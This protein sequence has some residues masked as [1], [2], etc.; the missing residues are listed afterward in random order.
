[1]VKGAD[2]KSVMRRFESGRRLHLLESDRSRDSLRNPPKETFKGDGR[3]L[4]CVARRLECRP[5]PLFFISAQHGAAAYLCARLSWPRDR[6]LNVAPTVSEL[7][8]TIMHG[9]V[10]EQPPLQPTKREPDAGVAVS[11]TSVAAG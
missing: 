3:D 11:V 8:P 7:F 2:C 6:T 1:V 10:P 9:L 4:K 5:P